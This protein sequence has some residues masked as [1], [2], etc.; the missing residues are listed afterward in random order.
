MKKMN[1][2]AIIIILILF[3]GLKTSITVLAFEFDSDGNY[4]GFKDLPTK[5]TSEQAEKDG[6]YVMDMNTE[7]VYGE[8]SWKHFIKSALNGKDASI[9]YF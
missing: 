1:I 5:Y 8:Q 7:T 4:L 9:Q 2:I 3:S 6:Y